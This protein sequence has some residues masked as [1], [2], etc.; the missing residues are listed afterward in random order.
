MTFL[1]IVLLCL[2]ATMFF[3]AAEMAF[4][5]A[6]RVRLRHLAE[7]GDATAEAYLESFRRPERTLATAMMGVTVAHIV[8]SSAAT[9][10]LLPRLGDWAPL[11]VT[12]LLTPIMLVFGEI[13]P[14]AV[15][16]EWATPLV[17]KLYRLLTWAAILLAPFV[18]LSHTVVGWVLRAFGTRQP[19]IRQLVSREELKALL[20]LEPGE[21]DVTT[22]EAEMIDK[23][24]DLGDTTVREVMV[25]LVE[26]VMVPETATPGEV[27]ATMRQRGF[28]RLP[29]YRERETNIV[30]VVAAM[31]IFG[32][33]NQ[34]RR[35]DELMRQ[36]YYVP[37]TKRLDDLLRELQR[38]RMHMAIVVDEYGG[39][40][41][42]VTLEDILE[43]IV[44]EIHDEHERPPAS[45]ERLPDGTY[46]VAARTNIDEL[47]EGLDWSLP[48]RDYET[49][50]GL[51]LATLGRIPR[52]GEQFQVP[53]YAITV[54][55]ADER[56]VAAV[57][58][59]P[60]RPSGPDNP[61]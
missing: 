28:S 3:S 10:G 4:I 29:V 52:R 36:P 37:E 18:I 16:R 60:L 13:I 20:S 26:V 54:L 21:A 43:E 31:D 19:D 46:W 34:V 15:A 44:G 51:V 59:A 32:R 56:R 23:I 57:K 1:W 49:V 42:I 61:S 50:A 7:E 58:I 47:N 27:I 48:K 45:V 41:G 25:P 39:S 35:V 8:A 53:G 14:K 22:Q 24:F 6:N 40:T 55:E 2:A 38:S 17:L 11:V 5:A 9:F 33:G 12:G 30:G